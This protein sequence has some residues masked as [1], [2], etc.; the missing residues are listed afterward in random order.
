VGRA[1]RI[2]EKAPAVDADA[3]S[4]EV[5]DMTA[6]VGS[7][8][9]MEAKQK[10]AFNGLE[11]STFTVCARIRPVLAQ[12][13]PGS[14]ENFGVIFPQAGIPIPA[15]KVAAG[16]TAEA[17]AGATTAAKD[18]KDSKD[19]KT[20]AFEHCEPTLILTPK[21]SLMGKVQLP[22]TRLDFDFTFGPDAGGA[23]IFDK[24]GRPLVARA[25][26]GGVGVVFA[27]GQTSSGK[28]H[29]MNGL[30]DELVQSIYGGDANGAPLRKI[31]FSYLE[32]LGQVCTDCLDA[33]AE[34]G[35]V[36]IGEML[37][38]RMEIRNLVEIECRTA[39]EFT[40]QVAAAKA[41]RATECTE[42][43]ATSSRSHGVGIITIG[44]ETSAADV[45][46]TKA[47]ATVATAAAGEGSEE[48]SESVFAAAAAAET[49]APQPKAGRLYIIDLAGSERLGDSKNHSDTRMEETKAINLSLM[50]LKEC[51]RARTLA[52]AGDGR[53]EVH[54][55]YRRSKLT[56]LMKDVFDIS[57][58]RLCS[59]VVL[60]H[61]SPLARDVKHS[62]NTLQYA[63]PL[64]V[65][66]HNTR[67]APKYEIDTRDPANWT[68]DQ[69]SEWMKDMLQ[70]VATTASTSKVD[71]AA[72][73][74]VQALQS[75]VTMDTLLPPSQASPGLALCML[76]E[77]EVFRRVALAFH[78][79]SG[80]GGDDDAGAILSGVLPG[81]VAQALYNDV[82]TRICDA[83]VLACRAL[84]TAHTATYHS[85]VAASRYKSPNAQH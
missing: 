67:A 68:R 64:R 12:D 2:P 78:N 35:A 19:S 30:M 21:V 58:R 80:G 23:E 7:L 14:G 17:P 36:K 75:T 63:A 81:Q 31:T 71:D 55:P 46:G 77:S 44:P 74:L 45:S 72:R 50:S 25:A 13:E 38:G 18:S 24:V 48:S 5:A 37:D 11:T 1:T 84:H 60:A 29:T 62:T 66:V 4:T 49:S 32:I 43:N 16:A 85:T 40:A 34:A 61:V 3:D 73:P 56:L 22:P 10:N 28:T 51:I 52:G 53:S 39:S 15:P 9:V 26:A 70:Q 33:G 57:C 20:A 76:P 59:T 6:K 82:W 83:K 79:S 42:R 8:S 47:K 69:A 65:S 27:Y 41:M 54:V